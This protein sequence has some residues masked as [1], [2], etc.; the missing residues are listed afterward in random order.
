[1]QRKISGVETLIRTRDASHRLDIDGESCHHMHNVVKK[2]TS[3]FDYYLEN[4]FRDIPNE[5]KYCADF[6]F[7]LK[8]V[9]FHMGKKFKKPIT[10]N[11]CRWL[12]FMMCL[13]SLIKDLMF[14]GY[15]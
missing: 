10:Y 11:T 6:I 3:F 7:L 5:F 13:W 2:L 15:S 1:M 14:I 8:E 9:T 12:F 4:L